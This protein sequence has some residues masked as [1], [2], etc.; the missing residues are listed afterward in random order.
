MEARRLRRQRR[1]NYLFNKN[2]ITAED[3]QSYGFKAA[4]TDN[5]DSTD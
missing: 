5:T 1:F 3:E 2:M 4:L